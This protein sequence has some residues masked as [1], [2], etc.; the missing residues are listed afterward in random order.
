MQ[1]VNLTEPKPLAES[2]LLYL[3]LQLVHGQAEV[4]GTEMARSRVYSIS[5]RSKIA[6]FNW[7]E[8]CTITVSSTA[9]FLGQPLIGWFYVYGEIWLL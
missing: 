6:I 4:F 8:S 5:P 7:Y 2:H 3:S 9:D 1:W